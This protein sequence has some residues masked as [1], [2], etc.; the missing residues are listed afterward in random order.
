MST[1]KKSISKLKLDFR[2]RC[3]HTQN[4]FLLTLRWCYSNRNFQ[5][6]TVFWLAIVVTVPKNWV[7]LDNKELLQTITVIV[8]LVHPDYR[9]HVTNT[10]KHKNWFLLKKLRYSPETEPINNFS[11]KSQL[12]FD[13]KTLKHSFLKVSFKKLFPERKHFI[14]W[15]K[16]ISH[17]KQQ[18][19]ITKCSL[20]TS[21]GKDK[22]NKLCPV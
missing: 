18:K 19:L 5:I 22:H 9:T 8:P 20:P 16:T 4:Q 6:T 3:L 14:L 12:R 21:K 17:K 2:H 11:T 15:V 10:E 13:Y 1:Q 7:S